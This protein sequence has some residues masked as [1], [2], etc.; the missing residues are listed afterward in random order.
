MDQNERIAT[1]IREYDAQGW[2]RTGTTVD[3]ESDV[4]TVITQISGGRSVP[5]VYRDL[6]DFACSRDVQIDTAF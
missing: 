3:H 6:V 1:I 2:H 4:N 5:E